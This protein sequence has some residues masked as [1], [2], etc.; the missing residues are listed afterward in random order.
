MYTHNIIPSS[1]TF[2]L[3]N[4][5]SSVPIHF[6]VSHTL[7]FCLPASCL[8][9]TFPIQSRVSRQARCPVSMSQN[10]HISNTNARIS[11]THIIQEFTLILRAAG[12]RTCLRMCRSVTKKYTNRE[13]IVHNHEPPTKALGNNI[14][15][16]MCWFCNNIMALLS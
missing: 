5:P 8:L 6:L 13:S 7:L 9:N 3:A 16:S 12:M 15:L 14:I 11:N 1:I 2:A 4:L 10:A